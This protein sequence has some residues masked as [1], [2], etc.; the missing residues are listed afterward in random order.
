MG[1]SGDGLGMSDVGN[2]SVVNGRFWECH[3]MRMILF[4]LRRGEAL[5]EWK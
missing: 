3:V 2:G 4:W 1:M 5:T